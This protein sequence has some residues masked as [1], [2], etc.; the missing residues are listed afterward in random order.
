MDVGPDD[1]FTWVM[2]GIQ[3]AVLGREV[4]GKPLD[5]IPWGLVEG[6]LGTL[7]LADR[8]EVFYD[9]DLLDA[10]DFR[11]RIRAEIGG[12]ADQLGFQPT[13]HSA[14]RLAELYRRILLRDWHPSAK[15]TA[16]GFGVNVADAVIDLTVDESAPS[17]LVLALERLDPELI[18]VMTGRFMG[19]GRRPPDR[20]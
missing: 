13:R 18:R 15:T 11:D 12:K 6:Y 4:R 19:R 7:L 14:R 17:D 8:Y 10:A 2:D 20:A 3:R 5:H 1:E 16:F 9:P